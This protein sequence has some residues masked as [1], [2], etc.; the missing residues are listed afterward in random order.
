MFLC[1]EGKDRPAFGRLDG[2][3]CLLLWSSIRFSLSLAL[4][5]SVSSF[6]LILCFWVK[7]GSFSSFFVSSLQFSCFSCFPALLF[8]LQ[9]LPF[10]ERS[11]RMNALSLYVC[12]CSFKFHFHFFFFF[13][14]KVI[15]C[16][17]VQLLIF[18]FV[19]GFADQEK[20]ASN[21]GTLVVRVGGEY[22][23]RSS[24]C[25]FLC[26]SVIL[27]SFSFSFKF[28]TYDFFSEIAI[29]YHYFM[30]PSFAKN[31]LISVPLLCSFPR[32]LF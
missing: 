29:H 11:H 28:F 5:P 8:S 18:P 10:P 22:S 17:M 27:L 14:D 15:V 13:F 32:R 2:W 25:L 30:T 6:L 31:F 4:S 1:I 21:G 16:S 9:L 20:P 26:Y 3:K 19:P 7:E 23:C 12:C 24:L